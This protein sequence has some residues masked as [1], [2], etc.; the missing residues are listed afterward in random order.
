MN[1][2]KK[3]ILIF[4]LILISFPSIL[5]QD[6]KS[7]KRIYVLD[8][9]K[10]MDAWE[11]PRTGKKYPDVWKDLKPMLID[12]IKQ[13]DES[14]TD[15]VLLCFDSKISHKFN[16][17]T[18]ILNFLN[19][20]KNKPDGMNTN[21]SLPWREALKEV[22]RSKYNFIT[23]LT[24]GGEQNVAGEVPF[25]QS[26][27]SK[28]HNS[29]NEI[30]SKFNDVYMC[31]VRLTDDALDP[32]VVAALERSKNVSILNGI[33]FPSI[34]KLDK[35]PSN[36]SIRELS[37][38]KIIIPTA[39][40]NKAELNPNISFIVESSNP[41]LIEVNKIYFDK[42]TEEL[43]FYL[44]RKISLKDCDTYPDNIAVNIDI[45]PRDQQFTIIPNSRVS[46]NF[47][48][49]KERNV[50]V[51]TELAERTASYHD[52]FLFSKESNKPILIEFNSRKGAFAPANATVKANVKLVGS[53]G[54]VAPDLLKLSVN[55]SPVLQKQFTLDL[56][57][58]KQELS[59][60]FSPSLEDGK[61]ELTLSLT[62][63]NLDEIYPQKLITFNKITYTKSMNP[64]LLGL[65]IF[66]IIL[67][68]LLL[69]W[70]LVLIYMA[71]PRIKKFNTLSITSEQ[72]MKS[73][74]IRGARMVCLTAKPKKQSLINRFFTG[75]I[76]YIEQPIWVN[77]DISITPKFAKRPP[78]KLTLA[79]GPKYGAPRFIEKGQKYM[80]KNKLNNNINLTII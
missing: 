69:L 14:T 3:S 28:E 68:A 54:V 17:K 40:I 1:N 45:K 55:E 67:L 36:Y 56:S 53:S 13:I 65:I 30:T 41:N 71:Y 73:M 18:A 75:K 51:D 34:I 61:Y 2:V 76:I 72:A 10:T 6:Q 23:Y 48:N 9:T 12:N 11:N 35:F 78:Y 21:L 64:L 49:T 63:E 59:V 7:E 32:K 43:S 57:G 66:L 19:D 29:W 79:N 26:I 47:K 22:D 80:L 24:D 42:E 62:G 39:I 38:Q 20:S 27:T 33:Q 50:T 15:V 4:L 58:A 8:W 60:F 16:S 46:L 37:E 74:R 31:F 77:G 44:T 52:S 70:K 25:D 5:G